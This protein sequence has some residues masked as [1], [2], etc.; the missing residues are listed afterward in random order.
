[1]DSVG[2]G[3]SGAAADC[4]EVCLGWAARYIF[5]ICVMNSSLEAFELGVLAAAARG[6]HI[7]QAA[8]LALGQKGTQVIQNRLQVALLDVSGLRAVPPLAPLRQQRAV[9]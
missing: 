7:H 8:H 6:G 1:M 2:D 4:R 3:R 5:E 9:R